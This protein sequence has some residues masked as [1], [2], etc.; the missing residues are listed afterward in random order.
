[1]LKGLGSRR[2]GQEGYDGT[3]WLLQDFGDIVLHVF[4]SESRQVYDL[5][6]LWAD[7]ARFDLDPETGEVVPRETGSPP[8]VAESDTPPETSETPE[9]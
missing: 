5:E 9:S 8:P 7:A 4:D 1:M 6:S 3:S 2:I